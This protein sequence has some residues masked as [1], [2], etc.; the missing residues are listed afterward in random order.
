[1]FHIEMLKYHI[2]YR[3]ICSLSHWGRFHQTKENSQNT[4]SKSHPSGLLHFARSK[5][6]H[7]ADSRSKC[8]YVDAPEMGL[9]LVLW[10]VTLKLPRLGIS[11][12]RISVSVFK[13]RDFWQHDS[14]ISL[15]EQPCLV[16][17]RAHCAMRVGAVVNHKVCCYKPVGI[18]WPKELGFEFSTFFRWRTINS[19]D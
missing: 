16:V 8:E 17:L 3:T 1:M 5:P 4:F 2:I 14:L 6:S 12:A 18:W 19:L 13:N 7:R 15:V 10:M 11:H 9:H